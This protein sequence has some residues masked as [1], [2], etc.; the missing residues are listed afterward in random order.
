MQIGSPPEQHPGPFGE[1]PAGCGFDSDGPQS[2]LGALSVS[3]AQP[4]TVTDAQTQWLPGGGWGGFFTCCLCSEFNSKGSRRGG[5]DPR[6][7]HP[8]PWGPTGPS[9]GTF[10]HLAD[11]YRPRVFEDF[12]GCGG[13]PERPHRMHRT[14]IHPTGVMFLRTSNMGRGSG[15][16]R[17]V[18]KKEPVM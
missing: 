18:T 15:R 5:G 11:P 1:I 9:L 12:R 17:Q 3:W 10:T 7:R 8:H 14:Q 4:P 16:S 2:M 6:L 13:D